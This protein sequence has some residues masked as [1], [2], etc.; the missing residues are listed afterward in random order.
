MVCVWVADK[1]KPIDV[2]LHRQR[3]TNDDERPRAILKFEK[4]SRNGAKPGSR[5][6]PR[7][8]GAIVHFVRFIFLLLDA[9]IT[10]ADD[11]AIHSGSGWFADA[12]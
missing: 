12:Q 2:C 8:F 7:V 3:P 1:R 5:V 6:D 9:A 10:I 4:H 11:E